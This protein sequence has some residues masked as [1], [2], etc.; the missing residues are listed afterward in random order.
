[1]AEHSYGTAG[2]Y[3]ARLTLTADAGTDSDEARIRV[4][5]AGTLFE[6]HFAEDLQDQGWIVVDEADSPSGQHSEWYVNNGELLQKNGSIGSSKK[7]ANGVIG[8][9]GTYAC[10]PDSG[11]T[12]Y[13]FSAGVNSGWS[14]DLGVMFRYVDPDNYYRFSMGANKTLRLMKKTG[15]VFTLLQEARDTAFKINRWYTITVRVQNDHI[16]VFRDG[17]QI[18]EATDADLPQGGIGLYCFKNG[19]ARFRDVMIQKIVP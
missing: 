9:P 13:E 16:L 7:E 4:F 11:W 18:L 2:V 1:M 12:D 6:D 8:Y 17:L 3:T 15:G 19:H 10:I 14:R 5:P